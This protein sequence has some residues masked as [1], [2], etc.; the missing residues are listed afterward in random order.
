MQFCNVKLMASESH[1]NPHKISKN[2]IVLS[3][4]T[5]VTICISL[6][7]SRIVLD[8]LG[9]NDYGIYNVVGGILILL[10]FLNQALSS[11]TQRFLNFAMGQNDKNKLNE[12]FSLSLQSHIGLSL[13][14][15]IL[16]ETIGL[17]FL[18][19]K[20]NIPHDKYFEANWVYQC[21]I[22][23]SVIMLLQTPYTATL[24]A[25]EKLDIYGLISILETI[26][27][28]ILVLTLY[29]FLAD[30][31]LIYGLILLLI[32]SINALTI[33]IYTT[34]KFK[35]AVFK[36]THNLKP[37]KEI[38]NFTGWNLF[39]MSCATGSLQ[40][41]NF[42]LNIFIGPIANASQGIA[43]IVNGA[44]YQF[45]GNLQIA[46]DP[47]L[48]KTYA[49]GDLEKFNKLVFSST[50]FT[51]YILFLITC[52]II[53]EMNFILNIWLIKPPLYATSFCQ[54]ILIN[55]LIMRISNSITVGATATGKIKLF[56]IVTGLVFLMI[57]PFSYLVL[58]KGYPPQSI[59]FV[60]ICMSIFLLIFR[61]LILK[62]IIKLDL[63]SFIKDVLIKCFLI[64][65]PG[66]LLGYFITYNFES[67]WPR[68]IISEILIFSITLISILCL[69]LI[70]TERLFILSK[71]NSLLKNKHEN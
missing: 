43:T 46:F 61:T 32:V 60:S 31:L 13:L 71:I 11:S 16:A 35:E 44:T 41:Q 58:K 27:K 45:T 42:L 49:S 15:I 7:T 18:N 62:K 64:S 25:N 65:A 22:I 52:P 5:I 68:F 34:K 1:Y 9:E 29:L 37:L 69:G 12:I 30:R 24:I 19:T 33:K 23:S 55:S 14:V 63:S 20:L 53:F 10:G 17:W 59:Y 48:V 39:A 38:F 4:R 28:L 66:I 2:T 3:L 36:F 40:A 47:Q 50:K 70:S 8:A 54:I 26:I 51:Y 56:Q 57:L 6:A 21:T 67:S